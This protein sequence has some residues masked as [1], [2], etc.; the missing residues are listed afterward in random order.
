MAKLSGLLQTR[1]DAPPEDNLEQGKIFFFG[2]PNSYD[3][4]RCFC[5][6]A[7]AAGTVTIEA[8][9]AGGSGARMCCCGGSMPGNSG[10]FVRKCAYTVNAGQPVCGCVGKACNNADSMCYRGCS[11]PTM[12]CWVGATENGCVCAQGGNGGIAYCNP[13][14]NPFNCYRC[15]NWCHTTYNNCCGIVCNC[16]SGQFYANGYGGDV[17]KGSIL[18]CITFF[19]QNP[20]WRT[21][22][23]TQHIPIPAGMYFAEEGAVVN[24]NTDTDNGD[25]TTH[26]SIVIDFRYAINGVSRMPDTG[27]WNA[28]WRYRQ[29]A[30]YDT[31]GCTMWVPYGVGGP[32]SSTCGNRRDNGFKGGD[33]AVRVKFIES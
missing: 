28:C 30:C 27:T 20:G 24:F 13:N 8:V 19:H 7:P 26:G 3:A 17:Q 5:F 12:F 33:G 10:A 21:C 2:Y 14:V 6:C 23:H 25:Y 11:A 4:C 16:C 32:G 31:Q 29:Y 15:N 9:G 1:N 22:E 18:S